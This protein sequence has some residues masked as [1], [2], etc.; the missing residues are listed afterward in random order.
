MYNPSTQNLSDIGIEHSRSSKVKCDSANILLV[1]DFSLIFNI[2][3]WAHSAP[4]SV[5]S[6]QNLIDLDSDLS[7]SLKVKS[8]AFVELSTNDILLMSNSNHISHRYAVISI[9]KKSAA[10][11]PWGNHLELQPLP[12]SLSDF[13]SKSNHCFP[14]SDGRL[15]SKYIF[16]WF[17]MKHFVNKFPQS[18]RNF[19]RER[20]PSHKLLCVTS[21]LIYY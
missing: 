3:R 16:Y 2:N 11:Y 14:G 4:L 17:N 15:S 18:E 9:W 21:R 8:N 10:H 6:L 7:K 20:S 5:T 1:Y 19:N 12:L 13:F